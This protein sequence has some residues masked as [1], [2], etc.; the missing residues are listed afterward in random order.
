VR[1]PAARIVCA[2]RV[3]GRIALL[4]V[5]YFSL[6]IDYEG[7]PVGYSGIF[8]QN[9]VG[10]ADLTFGKIAQDGER[11]VVLGCEFFLGRGVIGADA[12]YFSIGCL[13]FCNT[14][15]VCLN[16]LGSATGEGSGEKG[17]DDGVLAPEIRELHL[18]ARGGVQREVRRFITH[19]QV[20]LA[21][22]N[23]LREQADGCSQTHERQRQQL[24]KTS[25]GIGVSRLSFYG[26]AC[27]LLQLNR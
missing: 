16:F 3:D 12:K 23:G 18:A 6:L 22:L 21:G 5:G 24:H 25:F 8:V 15:L 1:R 27:N 26:V 2:G 13:K 20:S 7:G 19:F 4:D 9:A 10:L 17:E 14:S 11:Y